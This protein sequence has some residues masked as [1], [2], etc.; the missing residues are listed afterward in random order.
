MIYCNIKGGLGNVLFQL[1]TGI[2]FAFENK[3]EFSVSNFDWHINYLNSEKEFNPGLSHADEYSFYFKNLNKRKHPEE[4][5]CIQYPF[6]YF[7]DTRLTNHCLIEGYFQS[8]KYFKKY[9]GIIL[10]QFKLPFEKRLSTFLKYPVFF[11]KN[12]TSIHVRRG[13]Y[14]TSPI[15]YNQ[16]IEYY[17]E[18]IKKV[19]SSTYKFIVFSDDI[20]W[21]KENFK[22]SKFMFIENEKDYVEIYLMSKCTNNIIS[23]STFSWWG[24]WLNEHKNK[25][26][27][28]PK[29]WFKTNQLSTEDLI[30]ADW[31]VI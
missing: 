20:P 5:L 11:R 16:Q 12:I 10:Q 24:A 3:T 27:I 13:G 4:I 17:E 31:I 25:V 2:S 7:E 14:L 29:N 19:E 26:V 23:N 22:G 9:R 21:C 1:A 28:S 18:A 15:H 8:E 30:P 6:T